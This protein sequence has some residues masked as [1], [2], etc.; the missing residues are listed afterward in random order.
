MKYK[1][2]L[3]TGIVIGLITAFVFSAGRASASTGCFSDANGHWAETF[4]CWLKD[5]GISSGYPDGTY[6]PE[7]PIT[8][9][10]MAVM[11]QKLDA[12]AV[13]QAASANQ[14]AFSTGDIYI[15]AGM[16]GWQPTD[17][18]SLN[19]KGY[20]KYYPSLTTLLTSNPTGGLYFYLLT[21]DLPASL[22]GHEIS[23]KGVNLCFNATGGANLMNVSLIHYKGGTAQT[24]Y[25]QMSNT[26]PR[27]DIACVTYFISNPGVLS[28]G[29]HVVLVVAADFTSSSANLAVAS[30]TFILA[31]AQ[32]LIPPLPKEEIYGP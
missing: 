14:A 10:E 18:A 15:N 31:P 11:L 23:L 4:I 27:A 9:A 6:H 22:Y 3:L 28:I 21:P 17:N 1:T 13:S 19:N 26:T 24:V 8:R 7:S 16:N 5:N 12:L 25:R 30:A 29:D 20:V 2:Q 32:T